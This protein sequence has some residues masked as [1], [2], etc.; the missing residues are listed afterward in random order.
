MTENNTLCPELQ[1]CLDKTFPAYNGDPTVVNPELYEKLYNSAVKENYRLAME[2]ATQF[3]ESEATDEDY[4][5]LAR[6][7][8]VLALSE[9]YPAVA[10][11]F[12]ELVMLLHMHNTIQIERNDFF[13]VIAQ[14]MLCSAELAN[15]PTNAD[16]TIE[17]FKSAFYHHLPSDL[18][19]GVIDLFKKFNP[20]TI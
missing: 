6:V 4:A 10:D 15:D 7:L 2:F 8:S 9:D 12:P 11:E 3:D 18:A 17:C 1:E 16:N 13:E 19:I 5:K 20:K 14:V